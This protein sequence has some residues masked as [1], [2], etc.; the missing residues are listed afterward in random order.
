MT[1]ASSGAVPTIIAVA[2]G[3]IAWAAFA[4]HLHTFLIGVKPFA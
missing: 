1:Y 2:V 3:V 4:F